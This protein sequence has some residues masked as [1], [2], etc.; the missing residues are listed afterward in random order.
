MKIVLKS[1]KSK[2]ALSAWPSAATEAY[3]GITCHSLVSQPCHYD[4][5][6]LEQTLTH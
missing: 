5:N 3:L 6:T 2:I 4:N 1:A